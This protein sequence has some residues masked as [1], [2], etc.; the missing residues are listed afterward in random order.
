MKDKP[1]H[2][3]RDGS[4]FH[5]QKVLGLSS[6]VVGTVAVV[7]IALLLN[8]VLRSGWKKTIQAIEGAGLRDGIKIMIGGSQMS[9]KVKEYVGADAYGKDAMAGVSLAKQWVGVK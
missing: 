8:E 7:L 5:L 3:H 9:D 6:M 4:V 2:L 1:R